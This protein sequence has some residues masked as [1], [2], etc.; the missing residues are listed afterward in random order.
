MTRCHLETMPPCHVQVK[1]PSFFSA[2]TPQNK[3]DLVGFCDTSGNCNTDWILFLSVLEGLGSMRVKLLI[4]SVFLAKLGDFGWESESLSGDAD[5][6]EQDLIPGQSAASVL[7]S[8]TVL[9]C[10][11][12]C[13]SVTVCYRVLQ[14]ECCQCYTD[15]YPPDYFYPENGKFKIVVSKL[16]RTTILSNFS[17]TLII[18]LAKTALNIRKGQNVINFGSQQISISILYC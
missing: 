3:K 16:E 6:V 9:Q 2:S 10:V 5:L 12:E 17:K 15:S 18:D 13:Y 4:L 11:A 14:P 7:Q 8:V 1:T